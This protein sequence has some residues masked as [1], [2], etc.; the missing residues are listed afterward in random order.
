[1]NLSFLAWLN[2]T[3]APDELFWATLSFR[4]GAPGGPGLEI[5]HDKDAVLSKAV[6]WQWDKYKCAGKS[7]RAVCIFR[8]VCRLTGQSV[9]FT[10]Q[11]VVFQS[12]VFT[13]QSV[14]FQSVVFTG[15]SVVFTGQCFFTLFS[16]S[17]ARVCMCVF[18]SMCVCVCVCMRA[19]AHAH[20]CM[21]V[22]VCG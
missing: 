6:V 18:V 2:D 8:S 4:P 1:M 15:Q 5:R 20:V 12:V 10:G 11:S 14:V 3:W 17:R 16:L 21:C 7:V 9:V 22:R 13:G 19:R